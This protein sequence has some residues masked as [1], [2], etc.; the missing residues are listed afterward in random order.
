[1]LHVCTS[2]V[3]GLQGIRYGYQRTTLF[4]RT[5]LNMTCACKN[6][7]KSIWI[8]CNYD[9]KPTVVMSFFGYFI[10]ILYV[11]YSCKK[12]SWSHLKEMSPKLTIDS[13][14][15]VRSILLGLKSLCTIQPTLQS[16]WRYLKPLAAPIATFI[17]FCHAIGS[18]L[19]DKLKV[20]FTCII[21]IQ[22]AKNLWSCSPVSFFC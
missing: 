2:A 8:P 17:L 5:D 21:L 16:S 11:H 19:S 18:P 7:V 20:I 22:E 3:A 9:I 14:S 6:T 10:Q 1:M 15:C 13:K 4:N 12:I